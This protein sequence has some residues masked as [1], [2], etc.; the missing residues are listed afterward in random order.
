MEFSHGM[1]Q[2]KASRFYNKSE[3]VFK[4]GY[5]G[6]LLD[7]DEPLLDEAEHT[8]SLACKIL[9]LYTDLQ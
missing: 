8:L 7:P 6:V 2:T 5:F 1:I 9:P 4:L 3:E